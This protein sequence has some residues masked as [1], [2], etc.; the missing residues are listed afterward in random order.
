MN[1]RNLIEKFK[2][3]HG[4]KYTYSDNISNYKIEIFCKKCNNHFSQNIYKHLKGQN[5]PRCVGGIRLE[6]SD[7]LKKSVPKFGKNCDYKY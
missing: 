3:I 4:D 7:F 2:K 1:T 5:C 6:V